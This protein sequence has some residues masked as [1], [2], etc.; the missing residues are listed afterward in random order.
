[1]FSGNKIICIFFI[2]V[3]H[4]LN[5]FGW[6]CEAYRS[7]CLPPSHLRRGIKELELVTHM[8]DYRNT[9]QEV[10]K[11]R[12]LIPSGFLGGGEWNFKE[13]WGQIKTTQTSFNST[14]F[15]TREEHQKA[16]QDFQNLVSTVKEKQAEKRRESAN[17]RDK[18]VRMAAGIPPI[19]DSWAKDLANILLVGIPEVIEKIFG[20]FDSRKD[21]L[22]D[23]NKDLKELW[24]LFNSESEQNN[25]FPE[26]KTV[27]YR[28]LKDAESRLQ[29]A[30]DEWK[31]V[32]AQQSADLRDKVI[33]RAEHAVPL[34]WIEGFIATLAAAELTDGVSLI[35]Q[36]LL[37]AFADKEAEL[38]LRNEELDKAW[39]F[40]NSE[41]N[42]LLP[43]D[44]NTAHQALNEAQA[45]LNGAWGEYKQ[46][47][48]KALDEHYGAKREK[49]EAWRSRTQEN[50]KKNEQRREKLERAL[51]HKRQNLENNQQRQEKLEDVLE[52]KRQHLDELYVK[53]DDARSDSYSERVEGWIEEELESIQDIEEK[54]EK[55][56]GWIEED[57]DSIKDIEENIERVN[58]WI[59]ED[60][61]KL[62][63]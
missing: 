10:E 47:R 63:S 53:R 44:R 17:L 1:M 16:W 60:A 51:D 5:Q 56:N 23:A 40:F 58:D 30:W 14:R 46:V 2:F 4:F 54:L 6:H 43:Q 8:K 48:K 18:I 26:D 3:I 27:V 7:V 32:R 12:S 57:S 55:I 9:L 33:A 61:D 38:K 21:A 35:L 49:H 13:I 11:L 36:V 34:T 25:L 29:E 42:N 22:Q 28:S 45:R 19:D 39:K 62:N 15:P 31:E 50:L 37:D 52:R 59:A 24:K 41:K 20:V